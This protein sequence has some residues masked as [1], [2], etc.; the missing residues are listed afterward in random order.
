MS[1]TRQ[2]GNVETVITEDSEQYNAR[3]FV[4]DSEIE[5]FSCEIY[6]IA[7][8]APVESVIK[9]IRKSPA[10]PHWT[11]AV[12]AA[13]K[14]QNLAA[15]ETD[16]P[17]DTVLKSYECADFYFD[18][19]LWGAREAARK[20]VEDEIININNSKCVVGDYLYRDATDESR[21]SA[22]YAYSPFN[23]SGIN[24]DLIG[25][26][27]KATVYC[28]TFYSTRS[29]SAFEG[30]VGI[31]GSFSAKCRPASTAP[32]KWKAEDQ[33]VDTYVHRDGK[34]Y[35]RVFRKMAMAPCSLTWDGSKNGG[36]WNW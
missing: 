24:I 34:V 2:I 4:P 11:V 30:F 5:N 32:G 18:P 29:A 14:R 36:T 6:G 1:A 16:S 13:P 10:G 26:C 33:R 9:S 22:D 3:F 15:F 25:Q 23:S 35:S 17:D 28:C 12:S 27:V 19:L 20:D 8:W 31:N 21:G 7:D